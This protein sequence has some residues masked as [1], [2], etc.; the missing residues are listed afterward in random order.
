MNIKYDLVIVGGGLVG[1]VVVVEVRKN[2]I[3]NI[4]V[5]ERVKELGGIL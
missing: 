3:D 2:R 5:I 1:F 4:F